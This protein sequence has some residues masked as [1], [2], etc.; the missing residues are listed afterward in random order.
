MLHVETLTLIAYFAERTAGAVLEIG[1]Y[2]GG[3][4]A[5]IGS[6]L[7]ETTGRVHVAIEPGGSY[8]HKDLPSDDILRDLKFNLSRFSVDKT[9]SLIEG[10][11]NDAETVA[12]VEALLQ[13]REIG[14]LVLDADGRPDRDMPLYAPFLADGCIIVM[15]D[16]LEMEV[17]QKEA[18][19]R[20]WVASAGESGLVKDL[21][22]YRWG[23]WVGQYV[24]PGAR[25][26]YRIDVAAT[27]VR[28]DACY[29]V[30]IPAG[31]DPAAWRLFED[32]L[33]MPQSNSVHEDIRRLGAGRY[34]L[35][36]DVLY[37]APSDNTDPIE[38]GRIYELRPAAV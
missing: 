23:T 7:R 5:V 24:K 4:T 8:A 34:S 33:E 9:V 30:P 17:A 31:F 16:Y 12:R 15:D 14:L 20:S 38:T 27:T 19:V 25:T 37:F 22:V 26:P 21:G 32:G 18:S 11:S 28:E 6:V 13:S 29:V 35:W 1:T 36:G 2:V 10:R 3:A